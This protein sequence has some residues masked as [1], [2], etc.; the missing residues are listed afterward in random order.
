VREKDLRAIGGRTC[1]GKW[2]LT[3]KLMTLGAMIPGATSVRISVLAG[4]RGP[5]TRTPRRTGLLSRSPQITLPGV[6][7]G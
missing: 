1:H 3:A 2:S 7:P 5:A 4:A 6:M